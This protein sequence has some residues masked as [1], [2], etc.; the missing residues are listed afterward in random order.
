MSFANLCTVEKS[1]TFHGE[2]KQI[3]KNSGCYGQPSKLLLSFE[4]LAS[5]PG[6]LSGNCVASSLAN[7]DFEF[8]VSGMVGKNI[9][10]QT[11]TVELFRKP[12]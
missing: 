2:T 9:A 3:N 10:S 6:F 8:S 7:R 4:D 12:G 1:R 11:P 5:L